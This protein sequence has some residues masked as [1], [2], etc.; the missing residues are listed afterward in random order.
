MATRTETVKNKTVAAKEKTPIELLAQYP[1]YSLCYAPGELTPQTRMRAVS[2]MTQ[3]EKYSG[4]GKE[5]NPHMGDLADMMATAADCFEWVSLNAARDR[6]AFNEAFGDDTT[7]AMEFAY[8]YLAAVG[9][10]F[11][12][13]K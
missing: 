1:Q 4:L 9:E 2:M 8:T 13:A 10:L 12:S 3:L 5:N 11:G 6:A 7:A